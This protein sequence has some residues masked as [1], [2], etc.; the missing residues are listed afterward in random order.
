MLEELQIN[1]EVLDFPK[2]KLFRKFSLSSDILWGLWEK[3]N[4][5]KIMNAESA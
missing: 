2:E 4:K 3:S 5:L 1:V